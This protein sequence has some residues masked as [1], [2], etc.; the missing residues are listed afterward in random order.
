MQE[1]DSLFRL[2]FPSNLATHFHLSQLSAAM[3]GKPNVVECA[4]VKSDLTE[5]SHFATPLVLGVSFSS[6]CDVTNLIAKCLFMQKNGAEKN[7]GMGKLTPFEEECV[8]AALPELKSSIK[9]GVDF[10]NKNQ[11]TITFK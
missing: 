8:K 11:A 5:A 9:K 2:V 3:N 4:Y 6:T 10:I 7:L 1:L